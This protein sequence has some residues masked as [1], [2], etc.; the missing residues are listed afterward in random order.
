[1]LY[2]LLQLPLAILTAA[3]FVDV[4]WPLTSCIAGEGWPQFRGAAATG[5]AN[6]SR[7]PTKW[8][9]TENVRW[10]VD[11]PGAGA[12][13]PIITGE[14]VYVTCYSGAQE[15][16]SDVAQRHLSCIDLATGKLLWTESVPAA[17]PEDAYQGFLREHGYASNTPVT[18]GERI[19]VFYGKSGVFAY[20]LDGKELWKISIGQDAS[21]RRWG[22]GASLML[23]GDAL[24][25]NASEEGRSIRALN[26]RTGEE[27]WKSGAETLELS[28][29]T[30]NLATTA[31]GRED[32]VVAIAGEVWGLNLET[33]K[34][35]WYAQTQIS[36]NITPTPIVESDVVYVTCGRPVASHAIRVG[37]KG[38]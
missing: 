28:Y 8:S 36:G 3:I 25:V 33:G 13:S 17:K 6:D 12:S 14:R 10:K 24:I 16:R 29:S 22:S 1:M 7:P 31:D 23:A 19:Y 27:L 26:K 35:R 20:D 18:D 38:D 21:N 4:M 5:V 9:A 37:G 32:L 11:L 34:L 30:P 2:R 15:A